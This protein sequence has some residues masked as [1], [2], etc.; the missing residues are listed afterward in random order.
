MSLSAFASAF[1]AD[2]ALTLVDVG[3][4]G[5]LQP[6]WRPFE[7]ILSAV[8]FDPREAAATGTLGRGQRRVYPVALGR[9]AGSATLNILALPNMSSTLAPNRALLS[10]FRKKGAHSEIVS[11][12]ELPVEPLDA[13]AARDNFAPDILKVDT[14]G[15]EL[16]ILEGAR[17]ALARSVVLAEVEVSFLQR[18]V[19]QP[20]FDDIVRHMRDVGFDLIELS[21]IKRYRAANSLKI[22]NVGLGKGQRAGQVAYGDAIFLKRDETIL[23]RARRDAGLSLTKAIVA[24]VAY[25][26]PDLAARLLD[27]GA[28]TLEPGLR[29]K[30]KS[31]L[32]TLGRP[33]LGLRH[34][35]AA[36]DWFGRKV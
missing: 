32:A 3:S 2:A 13:I 28:D 5:G 15:S 19:G 16:E 11:T 29:D 14:Q 31:A 6:R 21:R 27:R 7:P 25:G 30:L 18:Y 26:K 36:V 10:G 22:A 4:A 9:E 35:H 34:L 8:L 1:P 24:L 33:A 17:D 23:E 20:L 12:E